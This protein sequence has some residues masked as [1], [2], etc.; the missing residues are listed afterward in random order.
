MRWRIKYKGRKKNIHT[1]VKITEVY[2]EDKGLSIHSTLTA[3][4]GVIT[5]W[6]TSLI[7]K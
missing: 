3:L 4:I 7:K 6:L 2:R 1:T 5:R